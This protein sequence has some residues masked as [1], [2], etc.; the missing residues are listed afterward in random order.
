MYQR[1]RMPLLALIV[2]LISSAVLRA[3]A[4]ACRTSVETNLESYLM[5]IENTYLC[6]ASTPVPSLEGDF[7]T[8]LKVG[9]STPFFSEEK[10]A[11]ATLVQPAIDA[12]TAGILSGL[13]GVH[14]DRINTEI[15]SDDLTY[16][17]FVGRNTVC[18]KS[19]R[20]DLESGDTVFEK[21][22]PAE[23]EPLKIKMRCTPEI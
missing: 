15:E 3:N 4:S 14:V 21:N 5:K 20:M 17:L 2:T 18:E 8:C 19:I 16:S 23:T 6:R 11:I 1:L 10:M 12:E 13:Y 22:C 9:V 7:T